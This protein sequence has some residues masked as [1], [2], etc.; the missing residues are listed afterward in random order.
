MVILKPSNVAVRWLLLYGRDVLPNYLGTNV[1]YGGQTAG[2]EEKKDGIGLV[3]KTQHPKRQFGSYG[4]LDVVGKDVGI[5]Q[6]RYLVE[7]FV[8]AT[9]FKMVFAIHF[10]V[11]FVFPVFNGMIF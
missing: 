4:Q 5:R 11:A 10:E 6:I 3:Q 9:N 2:A 1:L 7:A 8:L